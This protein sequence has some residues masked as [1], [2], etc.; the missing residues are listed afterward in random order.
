MFGFPL[1]ARM[2]IGLQGQVK[3][4]TGAGCEQRG[5]RERCE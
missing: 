2:D 5:G 3:L 4:V 1:D